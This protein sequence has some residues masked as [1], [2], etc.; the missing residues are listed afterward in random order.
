MEN[1]GINSGDTAWMLTATALV[2]LMTL[3]GLALFYGGLV[4]RKNLVS[5]LMQ[6]FAVCCATT[7][8]W[9]AVSYSLA[10]SGSG[11]VVGNLGKAWLNGVTLASVSANAP[12]IPEFLWVAYQMTFAV[13]TPALIIGCFVERIKFATVLVFVLLWQVLVYAPVAHMV[14]G[15]G[16]LGRLGALDFAGGTVVHITAGVAAL[17]MCMLLGRRVDFA[18]RQTLYT[19]HNIALTM[20]GASLL[21]VGWFGFNAGSALGANGKAALALIN[22]QIAAAAAALAWMAMEWRLRGKPSLAGICA[23][24]VAGLVGV[25][26]AAG[27]VLPGGALMI[28]VLTGALCLPAST[29]LKH[30][31]GYDDALDVVGVHGVGG[32]IGALL[33]GVFARA[34]VGGTAGVLEGNWAQLAIQATAVVATLVYTGVVTGGI[35]LGLRAVMGLRVSREEELVGLDVASHG[36]SISL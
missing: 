24:A 4:R 12:T 16:W 18:D 15:G 25:T 26:P 36:E 33:T 28:G 21:W 5:T 34:A 29:H 20:I 7:L 13:I 10:F 14:W 2:L 17:V 30:W 9:Y 22:T 31:L 6:T 11:L 1:G 3:P 19:P 27:Y 23:G 32:I 8:S 35:G